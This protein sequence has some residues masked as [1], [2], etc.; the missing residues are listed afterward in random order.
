MFVKALG[1]GC[2]WGPNVGRIAP[3]PMTY[4]SSKTEDGKLIFYVDEG[5]MTADPIP[6]GF[7]GCAGVAR[8]DDLQRKLN[9]IGYGGFRHHASMT[10]GH[11]A[12]AVRE[13]F[14]RYL[15]YE[16]IEL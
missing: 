1:K 5:E 13:A 14:G 7:F 6:E 12:A 10:F 8:I 2:G 3:S 16:V 9:R 4:A 11:V 15:K